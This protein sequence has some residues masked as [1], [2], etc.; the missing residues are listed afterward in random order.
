M[1]REEL[2]NINDHINPNKLFDV[3]TS[4]AGLLSE[5]CP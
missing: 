1:K 2:K 3:E 4:L 5:K